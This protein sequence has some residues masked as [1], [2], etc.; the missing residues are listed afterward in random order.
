MYLSSVGCIIDGKGLIHP[1]GE[2]KPF[3]LT[4]CSLSFISDLSREDF[5][6]VIQYSKI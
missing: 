5:F 6:T 2:G 1:L 4:E 3:T